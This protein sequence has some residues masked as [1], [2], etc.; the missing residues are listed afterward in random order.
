M[1]FCWTLIPSLI[2]FIE[3]IYFLII[4]EKEFDI[5]YNADYIMKQ[6]YMKNRIVTK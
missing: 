2:A 4:S 6:D 5:K 3:T 1:V